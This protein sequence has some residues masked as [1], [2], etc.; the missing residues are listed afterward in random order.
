VQQPSDWRLTNGG[1]LHR[2]AARGVK[3]VASSVTRR[4]GERLIADA[5]LSSIIP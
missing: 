3:V 4:T 2:I 5:A 1:W